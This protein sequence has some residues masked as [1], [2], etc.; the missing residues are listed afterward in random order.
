[1]ERLNMPLSP[2]N[3]SENAP[4]K[5]VCQDCK[6]RHIGC[7]NGCEDYAVECITLISTM[8]D[9][10]MRKRLDEDMILINRQRRKRGLH[11]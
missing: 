10:R 4:D 2:I 5:S 1:M 9:T 8:H 11:E 3:I 6:R 7:H